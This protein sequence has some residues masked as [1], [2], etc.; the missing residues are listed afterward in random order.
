MMKTLEPPEKKILAECVF[1]YRMKMEESQECFAEGCD[2]ST[3]TISLIERAKFNPSLQTLSKITRK[4]AHGVE[5]CILGSS[6]GGLMVS[7]KPVLRRC[8]VF[9]ML[10]F[11]LGTAVTDE[12]IQSFTGRTSNVK[13]IIIDFSGAIIGMLLAICTVAVVRRITSRK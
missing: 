3:D 1:Q 2:I 8:P 7:L 13:D 6:V 12:F 11:L 10:F 5:F 4:L 9:M